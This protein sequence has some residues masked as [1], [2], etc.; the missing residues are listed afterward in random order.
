MKKLILGLISLVLYVTGSAVFAGGC[1]TDNGDGTL[2]EPKTGLIW[3]TCALGQV[4]NGTACSGQAKEHPW[5]EALLAAKENKFQNREDWILPT[6]E[7]YTSLLQSNCSHLLKGAFWSSSENQASYAWFVD[8]GYGSVDSNFRFRSYAARLVRG[9]QL[10]D[11]QVFK[12]SFGKLKEAIK[13]DEAYEFSQRSNTLNGFLEFLKKYPTHK[14]T[15][16]VKNQVRSLLEPSI[17]KAEAAFKCEEARQIDKQSEA[18]G[19]PTMSS[20]DI[21]VDKRKFNNVLNLKNPQ[22]QYLEAVKYE[23]NNERSRAKRIYLTIMDKSSTSPIAMKA[24]DRLASMKDV[25]A[26][27]SASDASRAAA[28]R[29]AEASRRAGE[30]SREAATSV[31][32]QNYDQCRKNRDACWSGCDVY[33]N[34][35]QRDSCKSGCA[36]CAN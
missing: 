11:M 13:A 21:C 36:S 14:Q 8:F 32:R 10:S 33:K 19:I 34:S 26:V 20:F 31:N 18:I 3:Q 7:Q 4:W 25:E 9:S 35:S 5:E 17:L 22:Q 12:A 27:E 28:E 29:A 2:T 30:A 15:S 24:A 16:L 23:N 6:K 1:L